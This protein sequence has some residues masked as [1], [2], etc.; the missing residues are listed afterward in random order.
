MA[1]ISNVS[2]SNEYNPKKQLTSNEKLSFGCEC[3]AIRHIAK[4]GQV[5]LKNIKVEKD[6]RQFL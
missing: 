2:P 5:K 1:P 6:Y 4:T 3:F